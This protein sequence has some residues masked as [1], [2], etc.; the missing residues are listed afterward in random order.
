MFSLGPLG[1]VYENHQHNH[2]M[3]CSELGIGG[4]EEHESHDIENSAS[5]SKSVPCC[6]MPVQ[7][8]LRR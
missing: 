7:S 8:N 1:G 6:I 2:A 4:W 5:K 3:C